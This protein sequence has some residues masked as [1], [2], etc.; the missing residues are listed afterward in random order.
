MNHWLSAG[1]TD[2]VGF[3]II[4]EIALGKRR[5]IERIEDLTNLVNAYLNR[6][7]LKLCWPF[8]CRTW[9]ISTLF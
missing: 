2:K 4:I 7:A 1:P 9:Q 8:G 3:C 5:G 6:G